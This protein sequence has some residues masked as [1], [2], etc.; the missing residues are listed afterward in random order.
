VYGRVGTRWPRR[1]L[2]LRAA[3]IKA[4]AKSKRIQARANLA[5][6]HRTT[7]ATDEPSAPRAPAGVAE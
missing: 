3:L 4:A 7:L 5:A 2:P 6:N 1:I